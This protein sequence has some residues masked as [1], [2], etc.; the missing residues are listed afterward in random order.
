[1]PFLI[2]YV[3]QDLL[4]K[5]STADLVAAAQSQPLTQQQLDGAARFLADWYFQR[6]RPH[7]IE[8]LPQPLKAVLL[9]H[10][11]GRGYSEWEKYSAPFK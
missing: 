9:A 5:Y 3:V 11:H 1:M 4:F 2:E 10:I 6:E 7:D 8:D